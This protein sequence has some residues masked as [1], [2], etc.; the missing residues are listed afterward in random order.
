MFLSG[1]NY[2]PGC[3]LTASCL[4]G[5]AYAAG[6]SM[7]TPH[8]SGIAALIFDANPGI[9]PEQVRDMLKASAEN[10]GSGQYFGAGMAR[11]DSATN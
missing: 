11:A 9:T 5:S 3:E 4:V 1:A 6:T 10:I 7:A 8:V 2:I